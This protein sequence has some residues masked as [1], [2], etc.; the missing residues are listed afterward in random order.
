[1]K[2]GFIWEPYEPMGGGEEVEPPPPCLP[3]QLCLERKGERKGGGLEQVGVETSAGNG[4]DR[5]I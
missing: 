2:S 4:P 3:I 5:A 1:M